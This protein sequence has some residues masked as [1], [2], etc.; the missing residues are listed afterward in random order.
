MKV[1]KVSLATDAAA[2]SFSAS[3]FVLREADRGDEGG[4]E[5]LKWDGFLLEALL[6]LD[7]GK[8]K[9]EDYIAKKSVCVTCDDIRIT[10]IDDILDG[11]TLTFHL[12]GNKRKTSGNLTADASPVSGTSIRRR[13]GGGRSSHSPSKGQQSSNDRTKKRSS[14]PRPPPH[15][16]PP[17]PPAPPL[18]VEACR[19]I[20]TFILFVA[21]HQVYLYMADDSNSSRSG[22][23]SNLQS[24]RFMEANSGHNGGDEYPR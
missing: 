21:M 8:V 24:M 13:K 7:I 20:C 6:R 5:R 15:Q 22:Q 23:A 11:D 3:R 19:L 16:P 12:R 14:R 9:A 1:L 2:D 17:P 18:H 10:R 4:T